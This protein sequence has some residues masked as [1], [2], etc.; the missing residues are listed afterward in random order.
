MVLL[1]ALCAL[2]GACLASGTLAQP[3]V[4]GTAPAPLRGLAYDADFFPGAHHDAAV[5]T[6]DSVLGFR[7][8]DRPASH[9][10]IERV[11]HAITDKSPRVRLFEYAVTHEGRRLYYLAISSEAN[12]A[13]LDAIKADAARLADPRSTTE[14][15]GNR[16]ASS[17]PAIAWMAY[18]IHGNEMSGADASLA[19]IWHLA[20][21]TDGPVVS[22]LD[23]LV[24]LVDPLMNPDGRDRCVTGVAQAR[25][26]QPSVDEQSLLHS[27]NWPGGRTNHY[28]FD[29]NRDWIWGTQPESRGRIRAAGGWNPQY[30]VESHEQDPLDTFL[31]MPPRAPIN[32]NIGASVE[33]WAK[34]FGDDQGSAFDKFS[35]RYYTGEWN[36][37]WYPGYSGSW[38]ALRGAID[39]LYEQ[40]RIISD[41]VRR[42]EGTLEAYREAVHKQL[43][44]SL[45][46]LAT[47]DAHRAEIV[48]DFARSRREMV[49][50]S[51][52]YARRLFVLTGMGRNAGRTQ[53]LADM[54][55]LQ[56][57]EVY[58]TRGAFSAGGKDWLGREFKDR[59]FDAGT[60]VVPA[61]QPLGRLAAAL[62]ELDPRMPDDFL[63]DERRE[64]V[65]FGRSR[66]YDVTGWNAPMLMGIEA[67][68]VSA[69]LPGDAEKIGP[70]SW[71]ARATDAAASSPIAWMI[72][73]NDDRCL[74]VAARLMDAG[75]RVRASNKPTRLGDVAVAR[76]SIIV[77]RKDNQDFSGDLTQGVSQACATFGVHPGAIT[78]GMG[79]GD[80]PD[81]GGEHFVLLESPRVAILTNDPFGSYDVGEAWYL[82]DHELG[83][84]AALINSTDLGGVDL[85]RYNVLV[86]PDGASP[87]FLD[88]RMGKL[89]AWIESGGTLIASGS[90][91]AAIARDKEGIGSTRQLGDVLTKLEP[92]REAIVRDW[93]GKTVSA[94]P[95]QAWSFSPP[96][97]LE[98]P[99][100]LGEQ[101]KVDDD[102]AKRRD[103]WR[104][105]FMPTGAIL[106]A[107]TD[108]RHW[109][110]S[111][112]DPVL[113][114]IYSS[115]PVLLSA[116]AG[117]EPVLLGAFVPAE[118]PAPKSEPTPQ[119][120][121]SPTPA[122]APAAA[123]AKK[124]EKKDD[125]KEDKK[126]EPKPGWLLAPPGYE[127]RLRMSGLLWPEAAD[128]IAH[129]AY[130]TQERIGRG[131]VVLFAGDPTFR[132]AARGTTRL[133]SN[134]IVLG[135]GM[136]ASPPIRP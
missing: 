79:A 6:P 30:F 2:V 70:E 86:L 22:M 100:T 112:C 44:S 67:C 62:L 123:D 132:A 120:Q 113:P 124:D 106:A 23:H 57:I 58:R 126:E 94:D 61:R 51:S 109:I 35:W 77:E 8:G 114:V 31:L 27:E 14:A 18:S 90:S 102:E 81:L 49:S 9:A 96:Q 116:S 89:R 64:L 97:K 111:G 74:G 38:A 117:N 101:E 105:L 122:G 20:S 83:L 72:D 34:V 50:D 127:L 129:S 130:C 71:A 36:E 11:I 26:L 33:K 121:P 99:W 1:R 73:G 93:I 68:E 108:D 21:C 48:G 76:G 75:I 56:G 104:S 46:N 4:P 12:I 136:G 43:V 7:L 88:P 135:P 17:M 29:M 87:D 59:A 3:P 65:R 13:R 133:F 25:T 115:G 47:L 41:A 84:R 92:Y 24:V 54:L 55:A 42:P 98:Y 39:N 80:L 37:E 32:P 131:Q 134:A 19:L 119:A 40:A 118:Q 110:T 91:A 60:I 63:T 82:V 78:S 5:P 16:I 66:L 85:R 53:R 45:A 52:P 69:P 95:A 28:Y 107:R 128:R 103:E 15:E 125:K 10:Q